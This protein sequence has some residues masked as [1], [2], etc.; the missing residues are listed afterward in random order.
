MDFI[1]QHGE[2]I[3]PIEVGL[4]KAT[5]GKSSYSFLSVYKPKRAIIVTLDMFKKQKIGNTVVYWTPIFYF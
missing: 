3:V 4:G 1:V 2:S 5:P